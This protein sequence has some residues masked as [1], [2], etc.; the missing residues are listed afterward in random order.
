MKCPKCGFE[1]DDDLVCPACGIVFDKYLARQQMAENP[2]DTVRRVVELYATRFMGTKVYVTP[3]IPEQTYVNAIHGYPQEEALGHDEEIL[4]LFDLGSNGL[5]SAMITARRLIRAEPGRSGLIQQIE[6]SQIKT[7]KQTGLFFEKL[8]VNGLEFG[9]GMLSPQSEEKKQLSVKMLKDVGNALGQNRG[10]VSQPFTRK[11]V[12]YPSMSQPP[13]PAGQPVWDEASGGWVDPAGVVPPDPAGG[14]FP[15]GAVAGGAAAQGAG[16]VDELNAHAQ[17]GAQTPG[18]APVGQPPPLGDQFAQPGQ[19]QPGQYPPPP[20]W[21]GQPQ[22]GGPPPLGGT[23]PPPGPPPLLDDDI[24]PALGGGAPSSEAPPPPPIHIPR[25]AEPAPD[26]VAGQ[27]APQPEAAIPSADPN[28]WAEALKEY[29]QAG[30]TGPA[31][32]KPRAAPEP[33]APTE[34]APPPIP[35]FDEAPEPTP[36][37]IPDLD[38]RPEPAPPPP[39]AE[40]AAG[41]METP[42]PIIGLDDPSDEDA[43]PPIASLDETPDHP[44]APPPP[45]GDASGG[46]R[47]PTKPRVK[48][49]PFG[50]EKK[51]QPEAPPQPPPLAPPPID[52]DDFI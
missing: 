32:A 25:A 52:D 28:A 51:D 41:P 50:A 48:E 22:P 29:E 42:P 31:E 2:A 14:A 4:V 15:G 23:A 24:P 1:G 13:A 47:L 27:S 17:A 37:P 38:T 6:L 40:P 36:P 35:D 5:K 39:I 33:S 20:N 9:N 10:Q 46:I 26:V 3:N 12:E 43:P 19:P 21:Q 30:G 45:S 7:L 18:A 16:W 49:D 34:T 11:M 8:I 44:P